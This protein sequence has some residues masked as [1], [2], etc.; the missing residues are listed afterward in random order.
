MYLLFCTFRYGWNWDNF[1]AEA[2]SGKGMK[3]P[4]WARFYVSYLLPCIVLF[5]FF[6]GY[7]EKFSQPWNYIIPSIILI[8]MISIP[9]QAWRNGK[10]TQMK[11][12]A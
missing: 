12:N 8:G 2:N 5:I 1:I 10:I 4:K 7:M 11:T 9:I 6:Q 3:F